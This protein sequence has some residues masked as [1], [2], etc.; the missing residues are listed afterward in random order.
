MELEEI[1]KKYQ[2]DEGRT[3]AQWKEWVRKTKPS[4]AQAHIVK[5]VAPNGSKYE[6]L[7]GGYTDAQNTAFDLVSHGYKDVKL[8]HSVNA[9]PLKLLRNFSAPLHGAK[10]KDSDVSTDAQDDKKFFFEVLSR[11]GR[12]ISRIKAP[13]TISKAI[14]FRLADQESAKFK[15]P[16][17]KCRIVDSKGKTFE[18]YNRNFKTNEFVFKNM[19]ASDDSSLVSMIADKYAMDATLI[20]AKGF[21]TAPGLPTF[22]LTFDVIKPDGTPTG[23]KVT[24]NIGARDK[25]EAVRIAEDIERKDRKLLLKKVE[26]AGKTTIAQGPQFLVK[27]GRPVYNRFDKSSKD[28]VDSANAVDSIRDKYCIDFVMKNDI[29][30]LPRV[31]TYRVEIKINGQ[32]FIPMMTVRDVEGAKKDKIEKQ[33]MEQFKKFY[34]NNSYPFNRPL[35]KSKAKLTVGKIQY[36][37]DGR[38][39]WEDMR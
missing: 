11:N 13:E 22:K 6:R 7:I 2:C 36:K 25:N 15:K 34:W 10:F 32:P 37:P 8:Y 35:D 27:P 21:V 31:A 30:H 12:V 9:G 14:A 4:Q 33:A 17:A 19:D 29:V 39:N 28:S 38:S 18:T 5:A 26:W 16:W 1:R 3:F 20:T 24:K 23:K